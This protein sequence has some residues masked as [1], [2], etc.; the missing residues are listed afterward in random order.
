MRRVR[1]EPRCRRQR[2]PLRSSPRARGRCAPRSSCRFPGSPGTAP[3]PE[4][5]RALE[6]V[7]RRA[8]DDGERHLR[9]YA[10]HPE[11]LHEE[12]A[13]GSVGEPV[14][15]H[16]V[17]AD[18]QVRLD[19]HLRGPVRPPKDARRGAHEVS[20]TGD[21]DHEPVDGA[22]GRNTAKPRD[23]RVTSRSGDPSAWQIATANA[24]ASCEVRGSASSPRMTFT[25]RCT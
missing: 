16:R 24:S 25:M 11:E 21:I 17:L 22:S 23:H 9:A 15:L 20:H 8:R 1:G 19:G 2:S 7:G 12:R 4:S 18:V 5:D 3:S 10:A 6:L 13:F 14:E